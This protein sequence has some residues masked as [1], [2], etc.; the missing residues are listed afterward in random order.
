MT[1][2]ESKKVRGRKFIKEDCS[3]N[4]R[5]IVDRIDNTA[6]DYY[7]AHKDEGDGIW[8][9]YLAVGHACDY[10]LKGDENT[11][12]SYEKAL[13]KLDN[14]IDKVS[15]VDEGLAD[16]LWDLAADLRQIKESKKSNRKSLKE[17]EDLA[18]LI[19]EVKDVRDCFGDDIENPAFSDLYDDIDAWLLEVDNEGLNRETASDLYEIAEQ[20]SKT[21]ACNI[22]EALADIC[23]RIIE[24]L[25]YGHSYNES[26]KRRVIGRV[27]MREAKRALKE[28]RNPMQ[29]AVIEAATLLDEYGYD[30]ASAWSDDYPYQIFLPLEEDPSIGLNDD[31]S[32]FKKAVA[33]AADKYNV[34]YDIQI[35]DHGVLAIFEFEKR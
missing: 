28:S 33:K 17:S 29:L 8:D 7:K 26:K 1:F 11:G 18:N 4:V 23:K 21:D 5:K 6:Y 3:V 32:F 19:A 27:S 12:Y 24:T 15:E 9:L 13:S 10:F 30:N 20:Y 22:A 16:E 14:A 2:R 31:Y 25:Y 35:K 34:E